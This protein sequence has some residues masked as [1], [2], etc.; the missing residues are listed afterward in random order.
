MPD[1]V[2][3]AGAGPTGLMLAAEL[4]LAGVPVVLLE[5]RATVPTWSQTFGFHLSSQQMFRQRGLDK[6]DGAGRFPSFDWG[7][8][9]LTNAEPEKFPIVFPQ[10][11]VEKLL[12]DRVAELG[13]VTRRGHEVV[14]V[15]ADA[16]GVTVT[17]NG[18]DG[19]YSVRGSYLVGCDGGRSVVR[20]AVGIGFPGT[21][22]TLSGRTGDVEILNEEY[23]NG[24]GSPFFPTGLAATVQNPDDPSLSR[25]TVVEFTA[26]RP[27]DEVPITVEE[28][29]AAFERVSGITLKV[30]GSPWLTRF[31]DATRLAE[32]YREGRV[33]LAGDSAHIHFASAGQ[34]LNTGIQDAV[35]LGWKLASV[36]RGWA[37]DELLDTYQQERLPIGREVTVYPQV[38]MSLLHPADKAGPLREF[39]AALTQFEEVRRYLI[40]RATGTGIRYPMVYDGTPAP[41]HPL[42]GLRVPDLPLVTEDGPTSLA[43]LLRSGHGLLVLTGDGAAAE[44]AAPWRD[45]L[46]LVRA[47]SIE[48]FEDGALLVRPDGYVAYAGS[49][50]DAVLPAA[51]LTW[52]GQPTAG[53]AV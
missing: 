1:P 8:P 10:R 20:K 26:E 39:I 35:N 2:I 46:T 44:V 49:G 43:V 3:V 53:R 51:L 48:G 16:E 7:F 29:V 42:L 4:G 32:R 18:P 12:A 24:I 11:R 34:G 36:L 25:A 38:Q 13:V 31:G 45:R 52:F 50:A 21:E 47:T 23:R 33:F 19:E 37:G 41:E 40:D 30:A 6:F 15:E 27:P 22:A 17:V 9:G 5:R 14:G 28:F